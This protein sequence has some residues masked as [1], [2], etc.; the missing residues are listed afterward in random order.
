MNA[1]LNPVVVGDALDEGNNCYTITQDILNQTGAV[2]YDN[3][4]DFDNDFTIIYQNNFGFKDVN[5]A[6]G[7]ALVFK[8][9]AAAELGNAGGGLG[10]Q[11][12]TPS[13]VVEFDTYQNNV[14]SEGLLD[15]P[16]FDH[17]AIMA[18]GNPF[19]ND[20]SANLA[21]P[22]QAS[23]VSQN[24]ED[25]NTHEIKIEWIVSTTTFNVFFDCD[26]RL[27]LNLDIK[28]TIFS[29][30]NSVF[31][32]FVGS[33]G[34]LS[35]AHELCFNSVSFVDDFQL[36][37]DFICQGSS[38][39]VDATLPSGVSY[40]WSP[41][42]GVSNPNSAAPNLSPN[43]TT[44][45]TVTIADVCGNITEEEFTLTVLPLTEPIFDSVGPV[46]GDAPLNS[47]P[48]TSNNGITGTWSP[49]INN[50]QTTTY[51]FIPNSDQCGLEVNLTIEIIPNDIPIFDNV[52][53]IC[54]GEFI[55]D[56]PTTANNGYTGI[57]LPE[58]NN[59]E[60]TT[61]TFT[62]DVGQGCVE[63]IALEIIV[64]DP[65]IPEFDITNSVCRGNN[66][67]NLP[68]TSIDGIS[69][70]W[71]P[72]INNL[73]TTTYTFTPNGNQ[74]A[75]ETELTIQVIPISEL[76]LEIEEI[77]EPFS[78]NQSVA[79]IVSGGTGNYQYRL[80]DG[81][82]VTQN[83][84]INITGCEERLISVREV[85]G[86][87]N[88]VSRVFRILEYPK[89]FTPNGDEFNP[90]WN[91]ECLNDQP[92]AQVSIFDRYGKLLKVISTQGR[93][94]DGIYNGNL[95]PTSDYWFIVEYLSN[96][97]SPRTFSSH[98]T[99]KR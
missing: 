89:F 63:Q 98:F 18:N 52:E 4:I 71:T 32:G 60:T 67:P 46:C 86:C 87:S 26:L 6:D 76:V 66:L 83:K 36:P 85:S 59:F 28:T 30:D 3:P 90:F 95:M 49:A 48:N 97:N 81:P 74:C 58:L 75:I 27:T 45:Y 38:K 99:L 62:P 50:T 96:D 68:N 2:W 92:E 42:D 21:G 12:I 72:E 13:L 10:Y 79:A 24:I 69:G 40:S 55:E 1:Q 17:I 7:M 8:S 34:G 44:T 35:N 15:D 43:V 33:T 9:T 91:I 39:V 53:P 23:P 70:V 73:E 56:L 20:A 31:F 51:T 61:Y 16:F 25:G 64:T 14:P 54:P 19:H 65:I 41:L 84:F 82:W 47:L 37:D 22:V 5:G 88:V 77:S 93:G 80:D 94:W 78:E 57:W 29:S 11:G